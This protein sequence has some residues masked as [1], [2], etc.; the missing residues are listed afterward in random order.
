MQN[1]RMHIVINSQL[2]KEFEDLAW[3][4]RVSTSELIRRLMRDA[5]E[6][7]KN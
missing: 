6:K 2:K 3:K 1:E 5:I 4:N 7:S